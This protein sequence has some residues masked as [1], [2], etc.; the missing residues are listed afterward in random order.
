MIQRLAESG[1]GTAEVTGQIAQSR[2]A[3]LDC[4]MNNKST[5]Q[6][7]VT[8]SPRKSKAGALHS[9]RTIGALRDLAEGEMAAGG[10]LHREPDEELIGAVDAHVIVMRI[11]S[12]RSTVTPT[13]AGKNR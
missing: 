10:Q 13:P 3:K 12:S 1:S 11:T 4:V 6:G 8:S 9:P 7:Q 2:N 5:Q